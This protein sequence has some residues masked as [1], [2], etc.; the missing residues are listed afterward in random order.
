M[1][2]REAGVEDRVLRI[3]RAH[4]ECFLQ[5]GQRF[6]GSA[7]ECERPA[8]IAMGGGE[9]RVEREGAAKFF[10]RTVSSS[11]HECCKAER[12]MDPWVAVVELGRPGRKAGGLLQVHVQDAPAEI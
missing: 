11:P 4:A 9:V 5:M 7:I 2:D 3:V 1:D 6:V 12:E 10:R 8:E